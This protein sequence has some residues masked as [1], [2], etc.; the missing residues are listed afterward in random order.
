[1]IILVS[2]H[3][4]L[5]LPCSLFPSNFP[6]KILYELL[7]SYSVGTRGTSP[8]ESR[9]CEHC[10]PTCLCVLQRDKFTF[11]YLYACMCTC[12]F[13]CKLNKF[14]TVRVIAKATRKWLYCEV[15]SPWPVIF[16]SSSIRIFRAEWYE[17]KLMAWHQTANFLLDGFTNRGITYNHATDN[18]VTRLSNRSGC[19]QPPKRPPALKKKRSKA[20]NRVYN[21]GYP[22][23][24]S[25]RVMYI[26]TC[27]GMLSNREQ[28][29]AFLHHWKLCTYLWNIL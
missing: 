21:N 17:N 2:F 28:W 12:L 15:N 4:R 19:D 7:S 8:I 18:G 9:G 27:A 23:N 13:V 5:G 1:M 6:N 29:T 26:H 22:T 10:C 14:F 11:L 20:G 24:A 25:V 3:L 16:I